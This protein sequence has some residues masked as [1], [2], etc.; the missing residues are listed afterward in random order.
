MKVAVVT[1]DGKTVSQHFGRSPYYRIV[2]IDGD[3][4][5]DEGLRERGTGHFARG[6]AHSAH[7]DHRD[8]RGRHGFGADAD[9]KH[10]TMAQEIADCDVLVAGGMGAGAYQSFARAGFKVYLTDRTSIDEVI[11][12]LAENKLENKAETRVD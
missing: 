11:K 2:N 10:A 9:S 12:L 8:Q 7:H 5:I 1:I 3:K 4:I 6:N